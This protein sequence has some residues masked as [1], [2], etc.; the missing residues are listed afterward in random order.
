MFEGYDLYDY[1]K[2]FRNRQ[3]KDR[4]RELALELEKLVREAEKE[5]K[6]TMDGETD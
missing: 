1:Y 4:A 2:L 5:R 3:G 6:E